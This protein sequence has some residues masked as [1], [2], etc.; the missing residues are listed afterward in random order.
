MD[1]FSLLAAGMNGIKAHS[2]DDIDPQECGNCGARLRW[3]GALS[4]DDLITRIRVWRGADSSRLDSAIEL[5][6]IMEDA[7]VYRQ[8]P[9]EVERLKS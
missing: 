1:G 5:L 3:D 8:R 4:D 6:S 9:E 2:A 7:L